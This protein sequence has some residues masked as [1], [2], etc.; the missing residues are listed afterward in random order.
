MDN[1]TNSNNTE[2]QKLI[3]KIKKDGEQAQKEVSNLQKEVQEIVAERRQKREE[4]EEY[5]RLAEGTILD[6]TNEVHGILQR[7]LQAEE[8]IKQLESLTI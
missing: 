6:L 7:Q 2:I 5:D 3:D 8:L 1:I 4:W